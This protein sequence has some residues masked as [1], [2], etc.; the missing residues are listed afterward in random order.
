MILLKSHELAVRTEEKGGSVASVLQQDPNRTALGKGRLILLIHGYCNDVADARESYSRFDTNF[1]G[2]GPVA[3]RFAGDIFRF[4]WPG[5]KAWGW[6]RFASYSLEIRPAKKSAHVLSEFL[7]DL[8]APVELYLIAHS[9]GNRVAM[10]LLDDFVQRG[11]PAAVRL[12]GVCMMAAAVPVSAVRWPGNLHY[13]SLLARTQVLF[14]PGD[15]TLR[16]AFPVGQA[17]ALDSLGSQAV[18]LNGEPLLHWKWKQQMTYGRKK[19]D[20]GDYWKKR[21]TAKPVTEFLTRAV[22][23][24]PAKRATPSHPLPPANQLRSNRF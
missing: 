2:A 16:F 11:T 4:Y 22:P 14:S 17:L 21:E 1:C 5:D 6:L 10:E 24:T 20:H 7:R 12:K 3:A 9:L 23:I 13:A 15:R 19:Y 18:G 8:G